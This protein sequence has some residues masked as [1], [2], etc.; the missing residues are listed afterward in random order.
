MILES[1]HQWARSA[2][3][4]V[5]K[6]PKALTGFR[7]SA[8]FPGRQRKALPLRWPAPEHLVRQWLD[9]QIGPSSSLDQ[10]GDLRSG[11]TV[12]ERERALDRFVADARESRTRTR[13]FD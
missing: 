5:S 10:G 12:E 6:S 7:T 4:R 9:D 8:G 11:P 2:S 3:A 1:G 13:V